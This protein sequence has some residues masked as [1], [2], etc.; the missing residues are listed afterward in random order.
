[1]WK[2]TSQRESPFLDPMGQ[3]KSRPTVS[4]IFRRDKGLSLYQQATAEPKDYSAFLGAKVRWSGFLC[5]LTHTN[6]AWIRGVAEP[7]DADSPAKRIWRVSLDVDERGAFDAHLHIWFYVDV[8]KCPD[9]RLAHEGQRI[10]IC[11][12]VSQIVDS[13]TRAV[14]LEDVTFY[15]Y[16]DLPRWR[17]MP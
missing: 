5:T 15:V 16:P 17:P 8:E 9:F 13:A 12:Q 3:Y 14:I 7:D 2:L 11:G 6:D 10:E 4:E 1:M